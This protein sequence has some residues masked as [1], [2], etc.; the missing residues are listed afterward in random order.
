MGAKF[1]YSGNFHHTVGGAADKM[2]RSGQEYGKDT[3]ELPGEYGLYL[4][5]RLR[6]T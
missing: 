2:M 5:F 4:K 6:P 1:R 3:A